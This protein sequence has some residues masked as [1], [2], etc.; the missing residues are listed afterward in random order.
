M[1]NTDSVLHGFTDLRNL[2]DLGPIVLN[3]AKGVYVYDQ[4]GKKYLDAN[5]CLWNSVVVFDHPRMIEVAKKQY[6]KFS[7]YHSF[8]GRIS[9]PAVQLADKLIE[10]SPFS[11]GKVFFTNSGSEA[12]DT[13]VKLLWFINRRKGRPQRRKIITRINSYHGVTAVSASMTGK[14][15]NSEFGLPLDGFIHAACPHFWKNSHKD[16]SE[17]EFTKRMGEDLENIIQK[18]GPDTIAGFFAEPVMGA[19]G[20]IPPSKGYFAV[21]QKILQKYDIPFIADEVICGFGRTGNLWGSQTYDIQPDIIIASKC[22]TSGFFP[23]GAVILGE[24]LTEQMMDASYEAEEFFH[25]FTAGGH[26]VGCALALEAIDIIINEKMIENVQRLEPIFMGGLKKFEELEFIGEAR[27]VGLMG[28]LEMVQNK[29]TKQSFDGSISIGERVANKC[30]EN[31]LICRPLGPSIVLCPPFITTD[32]EMNIIFE[33]LEKTLK[34][35]FS[36]VKSLI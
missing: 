31:G 7:G 21:V 34:K 32:D 4:N 15:Y 1:I 24:R 14:P 6:E 35:V 2:D 13:T 30:I 9:E 25:G 26:P 29:E 36:D 23:L 19:G 28:A 16:E 17:E 10:I 11:R 22:I 18:E 3:Q 20:V 33:T 12:N 8:F 5:S 27:G